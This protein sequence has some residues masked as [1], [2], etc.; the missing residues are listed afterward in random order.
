MNRK[1]NNMVFFA[2]LIASLTW[3][4]CGGD[5]ATSP[6]NGFDIVGTWELVSIATAPPVDASNSTWTFKADGTYEWFLLFFSFDLSGGGTYSL[7][8]STLTC[9][10]VIVNVTATPEINLTISNHND[11]FSFPDDE[12]DRWTYNRAQ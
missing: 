2:F 8:G 11:T 9:T 1:I 4:H 7:S 6:S 10:G 12:G 5:S 3:I